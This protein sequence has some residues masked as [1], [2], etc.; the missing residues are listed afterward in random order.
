MN[1]YTQVF[2]TYF[3]MEARPNRMNTAS[4]PHK[5]VTQPPVGGAGIFITRP[6]SPPNP[7]RLI[8]DGC[9]YCEFFEYCKNEE[10]GVALDLAIEVDDCHSFKRM[11]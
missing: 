3:G 4:D 10:D 11:K 8:W 1:F 7:D 9:V 5:Q 6:P 2:N